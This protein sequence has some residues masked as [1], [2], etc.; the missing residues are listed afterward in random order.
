MG[1]RPDEE[2]GEMEAELELEG[3]VL[4]ESSLAKSPMLPYVQLCIHLIEGVEL[5]CREVADLLCQS[6]RQRSMA[7]RTRREYVLSFLHQHPP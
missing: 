5:T 4:R 3:V 1:D 2:L 7:K 6:M